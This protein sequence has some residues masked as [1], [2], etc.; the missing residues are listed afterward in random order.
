MLP[1]TLRA[2]TLSAAVSLGLAQAPSNSLCSQSSAGAQSN[3]ASYYSLVSSDGRYVVFQSNASNLDAGDTNGT[4]D[5]Y[6]HDLETGTT[7]LVSR[8]LNGNAGNGTAVQPD[9]SADGRYVVWST[10]ASNLVSGDTNGTWDIFVRDMVLGTNLRLSVDH[11]GNQASARSD[12]PRITPDGRWIIFESDAALI[13]ADTNGQKDVYRVDR[14]TGQLALVSVTAT[15]VQGDGWSYHGAP[16]H[17]GQRIVFTSGATTLASGDTNGQVDIFLKDMQT[18]ALTRVNVSSGGA[19]ANN[20]STWPSISGDGGVVTYCSAASTLVTGDSNGNWDVF[21]YDVATGVTTRLNVQPNGAQANSYVRS[22]TGLSFDGNLVTYASLSTNLVAGDTNGK[23]DIF[24]RDRAA[25]VTTRVSLDP[26]GGE[27]DGDCFVPHMTPDGRVVTYTS[28]ATNIV[29]GDANGLRDIFAMTFDR[30][31][32]APHCA[33]LNQPNSTGTQGHVTAMGSV[34]VAANDVELIASELP[35][36]SFGLFV[37]SLNG[38]ASPG[39]TGP[40]LCMSGAVGRYVAPGQ[41]Q[42]SGASGVIS[43]TLDLNATPTPTGLV[44]VL[45]GETRYFQM[46]HRDFV[47][48]SVTSNFTDALSIRFL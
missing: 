11:L 6:R 17:D 39:P 8:A 10:N 48:G 34:Q 20:E 31:I 2:L 5:I 41:V 4:Q 29:A 45:A 9:L 26:S 40:T 46:W 37:T 35:P 15:G 33:S 30:S 7:E 24:V 13:P 3:N 22:P 27:V 44:Q 1:S 16:S 12:N 18:G 43:I 28:D 19:Q 36:H 21:A 23:Q 42:S 25:G 47:G 32:G 14:Q 38:T